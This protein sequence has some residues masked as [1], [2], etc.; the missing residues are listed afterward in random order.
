MTA[1]IGKNYI[2]VPSS[3][4][5]TATTLIGA[6]CKLRTAIIWDLVDIAIQEL[7]HRSGDPDLE[8]DF[9]GEYELVE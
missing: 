6:A 3:V 9:Y 5:L 1:N 2:I 8:Q 7:D 4:T